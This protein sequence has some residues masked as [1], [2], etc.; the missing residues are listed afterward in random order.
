VPGIDVER[1]RRGLFEMWPLDGALAGREQQASALPESFQRGALLTA[2]SL[3]A[4][5]IIRANE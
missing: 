5:D 2:G 3:A 4:N 1:L